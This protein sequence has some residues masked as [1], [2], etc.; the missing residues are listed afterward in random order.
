VDA[1]RL[2][3]FF[4]FP[5]SFLVILQRNPFGKIRRSHSRVTPVLPL[6]PHLSPN[7]FF[8]LKAWNRKAPRLGGGTVF[9]FYSPYCLPL[10]VAN[11]GVPFLPA[12]GMAFWNRS[13]LSFLRLHVSNFFSGF[14]RSPSPFPPPQRERSFSPGTRG[15]YPAD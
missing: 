2:L 13:H 9:C 15:F 1:S 14:A 6:R 3:E 11:G 12:N 10:F 7:F 8:P 5:P 4:S